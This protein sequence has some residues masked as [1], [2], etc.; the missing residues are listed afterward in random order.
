MGFPKTQIASLSDSSGFKL[1]LSISLAALH[2]LMD[3]KSYW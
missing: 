1:L 3:I 2:M